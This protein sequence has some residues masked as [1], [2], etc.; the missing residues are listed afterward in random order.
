MICVPGYG[1]SWRIFHVHLRRKCILLHL[2]GVS[3]RYQLG[4]F[5]L[6]FHLRFVFPYWFCFDNLSIDDSGVLKSP[7]IIVLLLISPPMS[8]SL[9]YVLRCSYVGCTDIYNC[10]VFFL[11]ESLDHYVVSFFFSYDILYFKVYFVWN[12][13]CHSSFLLVSIHMDILFQPFT[14]SLYV[15]LGLKWV[16]CRQHIYRSCFCIHSVRLYLLVGA[17]NPFTFKVIIDTYVPIGIFFIILSL[18]L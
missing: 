16:S 17:F 4:P 2:D 7:T 1:L 13:D 14:F 18:F 15:S 8:V 11:D 12:K 6:M 5:G 3:W 10:Y 9:P